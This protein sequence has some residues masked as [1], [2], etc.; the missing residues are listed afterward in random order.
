MVKLPLFYHI[1][2]SKIKTTAQ[3]LIATPKRLTLK[4]ASTIPVISA[5]TP[6]QML[7]VASMIAGKVITESVT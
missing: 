3:Q 4:Y 5:A 7:F 2:N 1:N 6:D